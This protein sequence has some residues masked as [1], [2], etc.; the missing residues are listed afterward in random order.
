MLG[1][2]D[3]DD[4][5]MMG[6]VPAETEEELEPPAPTQDDTE[7]D[8]KLS[9][10]DQK[11]QEERSNMAVAHFLFSVVWSI[12]ATLDGP[13]R[14]KFDEFFRTLCEMDHSGKYPRSV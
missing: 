6:E 9:L 5:I 12:G 7:G 8:V 1:N 2:E 4:D 10:T 13:S 14:L 11:L 3:D